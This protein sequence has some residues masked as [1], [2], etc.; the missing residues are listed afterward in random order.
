MPWRKGIAEVIEG[1]RLAGIP[2][3][4]ATVV[5]D[6]MDFRT[7]VS[8]TVGPVSLCLKGRIGVDGSWLGALALP[9]KFQIGG[10]EQS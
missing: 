9:S 3:P 7:A 4:A 1:D 6:A 10:Q 2:Q 8:E 5:I